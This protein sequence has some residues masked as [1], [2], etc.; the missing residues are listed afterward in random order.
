MVDRLNVLFLELASRM[1]LR[2]EE[3][4]GAVEYA[5]LLVVIA[6]GIVTAAGFLSTGIQGKLQDLATALGNITP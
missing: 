2:R 4:Q 1:Q 3:G 5:L 6:A